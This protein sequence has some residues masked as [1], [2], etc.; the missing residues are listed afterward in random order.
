[1]PMTDFLAHLSSWAGVVG[2]GLLA[3]ECLLSGRFS[4]FTGRWSI[5]GVMRLHQMVGR[6]VLILF[7]AHPL[8][9]FLGDIRMSG[10][11]LGLG[12]LALFALIAVVVMALS[13]DELPMRYEAW[14]RSHGLLAIGALGLGLAHAQSGGWLGQTIPAVQWA[15]VAFTAVGLLALAWIYVVRPWVLRRRPFRVIGLEEVADRT[16]RLRLQQVSGAPFNYQAGQF[17]WIKTDSAFGLHDHPFSI[18]SVPARSGSQ[19]GPVVLTFLIKAVG[20]FTKSLG[21]HCS[22]GRTVYLDGPYG[23]FGRGLVDTPR[24]LLVAGGIGLAPLLSVLQARRDW[25]TAYGGQLVTQLVIGHRHPGQFFSN[26]EL[27]DI[28]GLGLRVD[29]LVSEPTADWTGRVGQTDAQGLGPLLPQDPAGWQ[30]LV[31]GP[32]PMMQT[33]QAALTKHGFKPNQI[34][35]ET[36]K[37]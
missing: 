18:A 32:P 22:P 2:M 20:D 23:T 16:W 27:T 31:C 4:W 12:F 3:V 14:R 34:H 8:F 6:V 29:C 19:L 30:V 37:T 15:L 21:Q 36:F 13:R 28:P 25:V 35:M 11:G 17:V 10:S 1:M 9:Y 7:M 26:D 24:L 33:V 5:D